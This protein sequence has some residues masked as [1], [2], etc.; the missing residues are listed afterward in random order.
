[1]QDHPPSWRGARYLRQ[2]QTQ[3]AAGLTNTF[4]ERKHFFGA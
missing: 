2:S 3:T 4:I 1:M